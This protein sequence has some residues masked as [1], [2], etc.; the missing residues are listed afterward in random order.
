MATARE[1]KRRIQSIKN[2]AQVTRALQAVSASKARRA[3]SAVLATRAYAELAW[4]VLMD[5]SNQVGADEKLHPLFQVRPIKNIGVVLLSGDRGLA[6]AFNYNLVRT[7]IDFVRQHQPLPV[8]F[9]AVGK[10]GRELMWR[11]GYKIIHEFSG[12]PAAPRIND[13]APIARAAID[14]FESAEFDVVY[15]VYAEF[16]NTLV[17]RPAVKRLLPLRPSELETQAMAAHVAGANQERMAANDY[18]YEP[19]AQAILDTLVPR[20]TELQLYQAILESLAS[21]HSARMVAMRNATDAAVDLAG[22]L[23]LR[24]NKAR[25]QGITNELLDIA[26]GA[27]ALS[28]ANRTVSKTAP[29]AAP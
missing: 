6:G 5:L 21:E 29:L 27:E 24:Y 4:E 16:V 28:A 11:R 17:Q 15:I 7:A 26:G 14:G 22:G 25:Q 12:L 3:Q 8:K 18:I 1:I 20:F 10:K 9:I 13:I 19:S 23:T 2:I